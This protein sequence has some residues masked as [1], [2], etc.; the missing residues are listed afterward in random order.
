MGQHDG[1]RINATIDKKQ[2]ETARNEPEKKENVSLNESVLN[3][4]EENAE[5]SIV[6]QGYIKKKV[7]SK[8]EF[9]QLPVT[10]SKE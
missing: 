2:E 4:T 1:E 8:T 9:S 10:K 6:N 3:L 7:P 5:I